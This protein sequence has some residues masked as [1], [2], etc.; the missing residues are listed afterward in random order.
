[1]PDSSSGSDGSRSQDM[2]AEETLARGIQASKRRDDATLLPTEEMCDGLD[3]DCDG[4]NDEWPMR[5]SPVGLG[6][7]HRMGPDNV[8]MERGFLNV[9][10]ASR[11]RM[12]RHAM[13]SMTTAMESD[14]DYVEQATGCGVGAC[15]AVGLT[16]CVGGMVN[17]SQVVGEPADDTTCDGLD[18]DCDG[19]A[20]E[21]YVE[22]ATA[23]G[24]G[25]CA[26]VGLTTCVDGMVNDSCAVGEPADERCD[27]LDHDCDGAVDEIDNC[28]QKIT[29]VDPRFLPGTD[30]RTIPR[31]GDYTRE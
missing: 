23:C 21:G 20:D 8:S 4:A 25:T 26:A 7:A 24:I 17:D 11:R 22:Q 9:S 12:T 2:A 13:V 16:T 29:S 30:H 1:M 18:D 6:H 31:W 28:A 3:N 10:L 19:E 5:R 15:A 27:L 14:E